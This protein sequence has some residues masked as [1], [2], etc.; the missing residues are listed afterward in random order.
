MGE[1]DSNGTARNWSRRG[2]LRRN[3]TEESDA[4]VKGWKEC[5]LAGADAY[6]LAKSSINPKSDDP[7]RAAWQAGWD[8][9][10]DHPDRRNTHHLRLAHPHRRATDPARLVSGYR[11]RRGGCGVQCDGFARRTERRSRAA[12]WS[13][14]MTHITTLLFR[15]PS[16]FGAVASGSPVHQPVRARSLHPDP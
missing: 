2:G 15:N 12:S 16:I 13:L 8:W 1:A 4:F 14:S 10:K 9:A 7:A 11:L 5:W 6:W 3:P